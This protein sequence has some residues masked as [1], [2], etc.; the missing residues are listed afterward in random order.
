MRNKTQGK[1]GVKHVLEFKEQKSHSPPMFILVVIILF[2]V[3]DFVSKY[4]FFV[5]CYSKVFSEAKGHKA[6]FVIVSILPNSGV[7]ANS[8]VVF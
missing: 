2:N 8:T 3:I 5:I 6:D 4:Q 7:Q 1:F